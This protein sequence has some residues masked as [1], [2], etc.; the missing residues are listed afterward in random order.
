LVAAMLGIS[1]SLVAAQTVTTT[2][3]QIRGTVTGSHGG[4]GGALVAVSG[5][6]VRSTVSRAD[7]TFTLADLASGLYEITVTAAGYET[8]S[9][10]NVTVLEGETVVDVTL[11]PLTTE[12]GTLRQI[13]SV[14]SVASGSHFN[15]TSAAVQQITEQTLDER[16][17]TNIRQALESVPG[18]TLS[19]SSEYEGN[20]S[21]VFDNV[22]FATVRGGEPFET[23]TLID[24]HAMYGAA[25]DLG[26]SI[27]WIPPSFLQSI[28]VV[29]G[30]GATTP[31]IN[32]AI[33][34]SVNF[35]TLDPRGQKP[36]GSLAAESD[37]LGGTIVRFKD[38]GRIDKLSYALAYQQQES[39]GPTDGN[40][41]Y[42]ILGQNNTN[43]IN[44]QP[45]VQCIGTNC[46]SANGPNSNQYYSLNDAFLPTTLLTVQGVACCTLDHTAYS[47]RAQLAKVRYDFSPA[48]YVALGYFGNQ[49]Y[50]ELGVQNLGQFVFTPPAGY[51]G[52]LKAGPI[53]A[54]TGYGGS[55][56]G[57]LA[58][59]G[60][61]TAFTVDAVGQLGRFTLS[62]KAIQ[63][64]QRQNYKN[65]IPFLG[66]DSV[67]S[68][69][70]PATLYGGIASGTTN[71]GYQI[72]NGTNVQFT[73]SSGAYTYTYGTNLGGLT[74]Q[75]DLPVG[76]DV[77]TFAY[78]KSQ[79][80][81]TFTYDYGYSGTDIAANTYPG[82]FEIIDS[83]LGRAAFDIAPKVRGIASV[84]YNQYDAHASVDNNVTYSDY[85][86]NYTAP[87]FG[88]TWR[89]QNNF[90]VRLAA[91][92]SI[93]PAVLTNIVGGAEPITPNNSANPSYYT[94]SVTNASVKPETAFGYDVGFDRALGGSGIV[95]SSDLYTTNLVNQLFTESTPNGLYKGLPLYVVKYENIGH[96]RYEGVELSIGDQPRR[97]LFWSVAGALMRAAPYDLA[98]SFYSLPGMPYSTNLGI[99]NG[100]NFTGVNTGF[101]GAST[102]VS[103]PTSAGSASL[104]WH[105]ANDGFI[106]LDANY[107][108]PNNQYYEPPFAVLNASAGVP[109]TSTVQLTLNWL[110]VTNAYPS[111]YPIYQNGYTGG[112][113]PVLVTGQKFYAISDGPGPSFVRIGLSTKF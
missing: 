101:N 71:P 92:S 59:A 66:Q 57:E 44:G 36:G 110:N 26:F 96:A 84:Y 2:T 30:P 51:T 17:L 45:F 37:G 77:Y 25:S 95:V 52:S 99:V 113:S 32:N 90:S 80:T 23:G 12:A 89:P 28:D 41:T 107:Y 3:G 68:G 29:K 85:R 104:G 15:V 87:R 88:L 62:A 91:G 103:I 79:Y 70:V 63:V 100:K 65:G 13:G 105:T 7:G 64:N 38:I 20:S 86:S 94:Y 60:Y 82:N 19:R 97:G 111:P 21:T 93:A 47:N 9:R 1:C 27:G 106:R 53:A 50:Q 76:D 49:T 56:T 10:T 108:G 4:L 74:L 31:S 61:N 34:G 46:Y 33:N 55:G 43:L 73:P 35:V 112:V 24:G 81:P 109:L 18:V 72:Y 69:S 22:V 54:A 16:D 14:K 6:L 11:S 42:Y 67:A 98:P 58:G 48:L 102:G 8:S 75:A 83:F 5:P 39:Q 78:D 40:H